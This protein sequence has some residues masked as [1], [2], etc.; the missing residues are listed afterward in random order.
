MMKKTKTSVLGAILAAAIILPFGASAANSGGFEIGVGANYWYSIEDA[1]D[2][3]F[4]EDGLGWML[5]TRWMLTDY[6]GLGFELERSPDNFIALEESMYAPSAHVIV[7]NKLY[8]GFGVGCYYYD[9]DFYENEW[10]NVRAGIK[11]ELLPSVMV[12]LNVNYRADKFDELE[13]LDDNVNAE[14]LV[15]GGALRIAL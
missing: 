14:T 5:S 8:I 12:D 2:K 13:D 9:G 6:F 15:F 10:Y 11:I 7:G 4:D 3:D 1:I